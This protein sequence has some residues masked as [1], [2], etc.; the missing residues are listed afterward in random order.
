MK[1]EIK[2]GTKAP[3]KYVAT[4]I[5]GESFDKLKVL[6]KSKHITVGNL[7]RQVL[8]QLAGQLETINEGKNGTNEVSSES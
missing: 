1:L 8:E 2:E 7:T 5:S 6:A 4:R 3:S